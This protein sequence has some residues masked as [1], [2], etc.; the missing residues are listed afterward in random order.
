M[1]VPTGSGTETIH[2][3]SFENVDAIQTLIYGVQ[4][5]VY[6]VL[7]IIVYCE[8]LNATTDFGY[9][10]LKGYEAHD[11]SGS[12]ST[13]RF[14][15]FN[16]QVGETYVWNDKFSFNGTEPSGTAVLTAAVQLLIAAQ[17]TATVQE[18]QFTMTHAT[19]D[20]NIN[21]TYLDQDWT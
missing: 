9:L 2:A 21:I 5:H 1:A 17:G 7:S 3:H 11:T 4:H 18:L 20:Y 16:P 15:R 6:T 12:G 13:M 19:D 8:V 10:Q 14:A